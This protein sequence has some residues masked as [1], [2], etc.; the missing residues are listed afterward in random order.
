MRIFVINRVKQLTL[1]MLNNCQMY[2]QVF[3]LLD[4]VTGAGNQIQT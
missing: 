1:Q 3:L 2:L 4:I